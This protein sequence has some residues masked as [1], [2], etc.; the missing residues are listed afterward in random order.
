MSAPPQR[1]AAGTL[2]E[3]PAHPTAELQ[4]RLEDA[5]AS[6]DRLW[7]RGRL[8]GVKEATNGSPAERKWW[9]RWRKTEPPAPPPLLHLET[10][11]S[12]STLQA[13]VPLSPDGRFEAA[14]KVPLARPRRGWRVAR[15][16]AT[17]EGATL[18]GCGVVLAPREGSAGVVVIVLPLEYT[19]KPAGVQ[20]FAHSEFAGRLANLLRN[21]AEGPGGKHAIYYLAAV[22]PEGERRQAEWALAAMGLGWP[23][24]QFVLLPGEGD[25]A[26]AELLRGV[27]RLRWLFA[28]GLDLL[29]L[30]L[31]PAV[32]APLTAGIEPAEDRAAIRRLVNPEDDPW[33]LFDHLAHPNPRVHAGGLRRVR[34][35][36]V[37][38]HPVVF[39]HGMLACTA[40]KMQLPED[41]NSF[42]ALREF[43]RE[44]GVQALFPQVAPTS[45]VI[46]RA[47]QLCDQ[48]TR[49]TD[50]PVNLIAHSMGGLDARHMI[51]HLGMGQRV[52]NLTTISTPHR[53]TYLADWFLLNYRQRVPLLRA[54]EALGI[55]VDGFRA[56][57]PEACREFNARTPDDPRVR[58]FSYGAEVPQWRVAPF[59]RRA[60]A[61]LTPVEGPNDGMVSLT[62]ARWGEY[63]GTI[64]ADHFAQTPDAMFL[65]PGEDFDALGFYCRLVEDLARRGF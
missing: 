58:Y 56:C 7:V 28:G 4:L 32:A 37:P 24:G 19:S 14:L 22:P 8:I 53:G 38:R 57:R 46:E 34:C 33:K 36:L 39:C 6:Q 50:E 10:R 18:E 49:W 40:L 42:C 62:S 64:H 35:E 41:L 63:L 59:L 51:T 31:E 15:H 61:V 2:P 25:A 1:E 27:D 60:W 20:R 13:D 12:G 23:S 65:R 30:N 55:S 45:G 5:L 16:R 47:Q 44:R 17:H 43:L 48:I 3:R 54:M 29:V 52:A 11:V 21:L 9:D 26:R